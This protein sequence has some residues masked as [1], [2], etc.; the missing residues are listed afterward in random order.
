MQHSPPR[1]AD[2]S[3]TSQ[4]IEHLSWNPKVHSLFTRELLEPVLSQLNPVHTLMSYFYK[5]H[6]QISFEI[7]FDV[8]HVAR[9]TDEKCKQDFGW[10][11]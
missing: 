9:M 7:V 2:S 6:L 1:A 4:E 8:V 5:I 11:T 10:E 3:S